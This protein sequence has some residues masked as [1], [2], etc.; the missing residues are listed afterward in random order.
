MPSVL[1]L[2]LA[3]K[4]VGVHL[5]LLRN[6]CEPSS[7]SKPHITVRY[8]DKLSIPEAH[9]RTAVSH[10]DL[11]E[12]GTFGLELGNDQSNKTV[13][14]RCRCDELLP[15][16]H[17]PYFPTSEFHI[18]LY[19]GT[20]KNFARLL[21]RLLRKYNWAFQVPLPSEIELTAIKIRP[22]NRRKQAHTLE[23]EYNPKVVSL[24]KRLTQENLN[25]DFLNSLSDK[26]RLE[27]VALVCESLL[28]LTESF[29][30]V[31]VPTRKKFSRLPGQASDY[32]IH[33]TP[34]E[35]AQSIAAYACK[36]LDRAD[37]NNINFGDPAVGT[38]AF[39]GALLS[40]KDRS[41]IDSAI[42]ID[43]SPRQ[44]EAARLRWNSK[45]MKV[46]EADYLHMGDIP[47]RNLIL[48][49][50]PYLRHQGID[51]DYK[52]ELRIRASLDMGMRISGLS[53]QYVYFI[54]LSHKWMSPGAIA[55]WLIP[56][57][58]M[59][60]GYGKAL[61]HYLSRTVKLIRI[62]Q[63]SSD[64]PQFENAETLPCIIVFKNVAP[65]DLPSAKFTF[66]GTLENPTS[67]QDVI[68]G[69]LD[70]EQKW[71]IKPKNIAHR[72]ES[73]VRLGDLFA[74]RR[75]IATGANQFFVLDRN[76][77]KELGIPKKAL[78]PILPKAM[79][80][81]SDVVEQERDGYP[82]VA[83]QLCVIDTDMA[84]DEIKNKYP[85]FAEYLKKGAQEGVKNGHLVGRR[86]PWYRQER[87]DPAPFLCTYMGK[88]HGDKP[89]IRFIWNKSAAIVTNTYLML[90]PHASV[91]R[92]MDE[93]N[94]V[95]SKLFDIL[96]R[97][98]WEAMAE[99]S[100]LHAGG[101]SKIE[102][103]ELLEVWLGPVPPEIKAVANPRLF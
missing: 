20:S 17:K 28:S 19:D 10:I 13:F 11:L 93:N 75:G 80:L 39:Y 23:R 35:L 101:L 32:E 2:Y 86:V 50:P 99:F 59:Q 30:R 87:R 22:K 40:V 98:T 88:A 78:R 56:S 55:A 57:E 84:E 7:K 67:S 95:T 66:G 68:V 60:T 79:S 92:L 25:S 29:A 62:H 61:R 21:A 89:A 4:I 85:E 100:R 44:V 38:G 54:L 77:A 26:M 64:A 42:G 97:S 73:G 58:F 83:R 90:Y 65:L 41:S 15:L 31:T 81:S 53:G 3:D 1:V 36:F 102:P 51:P 72:D 96:K 91:R 48:A 69:N 46:I 12:V 82:Q 33:L 5:E 14:I 70:S 9:L 63:F 49:N 43:I 45:D 47:Q 27:Y 24:F 74:V 103:R 16:E 76:V 71:H 6:I 34:P 8:S 52:K 37:Q 94:E 18:T